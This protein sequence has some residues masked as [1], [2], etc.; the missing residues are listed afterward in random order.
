MILSKDETVE[1]SIIFK[2]NIIM[3]CFVIKIFAWNVLQFPLEKI[4]SQLYA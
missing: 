3:E 2:Q 1:S 4:W